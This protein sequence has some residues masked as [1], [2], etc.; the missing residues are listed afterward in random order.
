MA[1]L[2]EEEKEIN[3]SLHKSRVKKVQ[4]LE[5]TDPSSIVMNFNSQFSSE[6]FIDL[7]LPFPIS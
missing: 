4:K 2:K 6:T 3:I 5:L 7:F 1:V